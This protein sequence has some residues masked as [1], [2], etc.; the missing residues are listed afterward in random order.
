MTS[1]TSWNYF[2]LLKMKRHTESNLLPF[3][4]NLIQ[5][6]MRGPSFPS[7]FSFQKYVIA[8]SSFGLFR[9]AVEI[10]N[11]TDAENHKVM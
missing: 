7:I 11:A 9:K 8:T 5:Q 10:K 2:N 1:T 6:V 4:N 3:K